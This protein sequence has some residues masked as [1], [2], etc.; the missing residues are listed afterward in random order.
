M[1]KSRAGVLLGKFS[2]VQRNFFCRRSISVNRCLMQT[3]RRDLEAEGEA[4]GYCRQLAGTL[5][6]GIG[7]R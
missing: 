4:D 1:C 5:T 6:S 7:P 2:M 3:P